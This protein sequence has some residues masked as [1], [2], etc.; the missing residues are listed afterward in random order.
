MA[1]RKQ[2]QDPVAPIRPDLKARFKKLMEHPVQNIVAPKHTV[3]GFPTKNINNLWR[4][5]TL[6]DV[7][8]GTNY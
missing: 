7:K 1:K 4:W 5:D 8:D 3:A 6:E 2:R